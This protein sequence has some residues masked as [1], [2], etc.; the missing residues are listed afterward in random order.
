MKRLAITPRELTQFSLENTLKKFY[1]GSSS[2]VLS[3]L[4]KSSNTIIEANKEFRYL[5]TNKKLL[6]EIES[7]KPDH[8]QRK[9]A[10]EVSEFKNIYISI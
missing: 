10:I 5:D 3:R 8:E 4:N 9:L 1:S 2:N 6:K 7:I